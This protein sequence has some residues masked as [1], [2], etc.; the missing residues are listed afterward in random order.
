LPPQDQ[1]ASQLAYDH[2]SGRVNSEQGTVN[3]GQR[4]EVSE[5]PGDRGQE[6]EDRSLVLSPGRAF[7]GSQGWSEPKACGTPGTNTQPRSVEASRR[8]FA[9]L[10][11][12]S[13]D[14]GLFAFLS[15]G[16]ALLRTAPPLATGSR[17]SRAQNNQ[18]L[19]TIRS[20]EV[21]RG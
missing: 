16:Y 4:S 7:A 21:S 11:F 14:R 2:G 9:S 13:V 5:R 15:R 6:S 8:W 1:I 20:V 18:R 19:K 17:P 12:R 10:G 3:R